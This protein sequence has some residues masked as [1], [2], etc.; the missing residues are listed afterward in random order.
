MNAPESELY[1]PLAQSTGKVALH[2]E[3]FGS[4][5]LEAGRGLG[6]WMEINV[7]G[8]SSPLLHESETPGPWSRRI[9]LHKEVVFGKPVDELR[10]LT[11]LVHQDGTAQAQRPAGSL[12]IGFM[13]LRC[14]YEAAA[15]P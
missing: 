10:I 5:H 11:R 14:D 4:A 13:S 1:I 7:N 3:I 8:I 12:S 15:L 6:D 9:L 2:L